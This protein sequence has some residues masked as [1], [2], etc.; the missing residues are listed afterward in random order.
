MEV[1]QL[2]GNARFDKLTNLDIKT[3][4]RDRE[5]WLM[6][7]DFLGAFACWVVRQSPY[8]VPN[9]IMFMDA[10]NAFNDYVDGIF[11]DDL[12]KLFSYKELSSLID[13]DVFE[14]IPEIELLN[15][16]KIDVGQTMMFSSR[17][18]TPKADY[19]F[20][21]LGA[22]ARNVFYMILRGSITQGD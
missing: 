5:Y 16:P 13:E 8:D 20:I 10:L 11:S 9:G 7:S 14:A 22:L 19:D 12:V 18:D 21:D 2:E 6:R 4:Y 1:I 17:Y 3:H 15:H